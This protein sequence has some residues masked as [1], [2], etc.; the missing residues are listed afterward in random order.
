[1]SERLPQN[2]IPIHFDL[3]LH[4]ENDHY[5]F[6]ANQTDDKLYLNIDPKFI[7]I[8]KK[9]YPKQFKS[10]IYCKSSE[11]NYSSS[12]HPYVPISNSSEYFSKANFTT[13]PT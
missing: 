4:F 6:D 5:P 10:R 2:Y 1:M 7:T 13:L 3:Y 9:H 11:F 12:N 8:K